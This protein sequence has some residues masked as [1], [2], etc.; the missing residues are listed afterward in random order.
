MNKPRLFFILA[1]VF[2]FAAGV[3]A[4]V[5]AERLLFAKKPGIRPGGRGPVPSHDRWAKELGLTE[6]QKAKIQEIFKKN[7]ERMKDL[8][9]EYEKFRS[10]FDKRVAVVREELQKEIDAVLTPEQRKKQ[11]EMIQRARDAR[12]REMERRNPPP[13]PRSKNNPQGNPMKERTDEEKS[14]PW[15]GDNHNYRGSHP[16]LHP[17]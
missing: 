5:F 16:G 12:R 4:G 15:G 11:E 13:R 7:E 1:L 6:E 17:H 10:E 14:N 9:A 8:R 3:V 2:V